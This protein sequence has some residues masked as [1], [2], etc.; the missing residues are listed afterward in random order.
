M[1]EKYTSL[2]CQTKVKLQIISPVIKDKFG[3]QK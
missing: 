1:G 2:Q 3:A